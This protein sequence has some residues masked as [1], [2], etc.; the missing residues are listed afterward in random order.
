LLD[1]VLFL[2]GPQRSDFGL[3]SFDRFENQACDH[4]C[5]GAAGQPALQLEGT[6]L[7]WRNTFTADVFAEQGS[8]H[9][10]CLCKWGPSTFTVRRRVLPSGKPP[11]EAVTLECPDPTWAIEYEHFKDLCTR[12]ENNLENDLW[13]NGVLSQLARRA[14]AGP[15]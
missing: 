4:F 6:L 5:L 11:E 9:I 7:S 1:L 8:A 12:G 13:I 15:S 10:H 3:W 14:G 2:W